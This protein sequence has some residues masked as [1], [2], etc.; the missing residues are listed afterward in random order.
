MSGL[1]N[2][3]GFLGLSLPNSLIWEKCYLLT[4]FDDYRLRLTRISAFF[5]HAKIFV[6]IRSRVGGDLTAK[7]RDSSANHRNSFANEEV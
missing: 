3:T 2:N 5:F 1:I 6:M 7:Q 4:K